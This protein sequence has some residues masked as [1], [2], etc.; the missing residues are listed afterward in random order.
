VPRIAF[1]AALFSALIALFGGVAAAAGPDAKASFRALTDAR[2]GRQP[3]FWQCAPV[4]YSKRKLQCWAEI[5]RGARFRRVS[6]MATAPPSAPRFTKLRSQAW[7]RRWARLP[8]SIVHDF[9]ARGTAS[10]NGPAYDWAFLLGFADSAF[11]GHK[12]PAS[13][14]IFD[15]NSSGFPRA[16][17]RFHCALAGRTITCT[18]ALGDAL[19]YVPA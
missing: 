7:T 11:K 9:G 4:N 13:S 16:M 6:A 10:A 17:F 2:Y 15:G 12:L 3:G 14:I 1:Q 18:N 5:H 19:R 8:P